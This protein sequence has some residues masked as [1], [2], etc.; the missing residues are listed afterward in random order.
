MTATRFS[1]RL[2]SVVAALVLAACGGEGAPSPDAEAAMA[3]DSTIKPV[4][5][6]PLTEADLMGFALSDLSVELPWTQNRVSRDPAP[7]QGPG[8]LESAETSSGE[9]FARVVF[10]FS[11][12]AYF[13]GYEVGFVDAGADVPCG[14][15]GKALSLSG[16][17]ALVIRLK[18]ANAH[19]TEGVRVPVRTR[20]L[21]PEQFTEGGLVCDLNDNVVWA[22]GLNSG[23]QVRV[24]EFRNPKRLAVDIR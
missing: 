1:S 2:V 6:E 22:A 18:P 19:D 12:I 3:V 11:D 4:A 9:G 13:P 15:Q 7:A 21:S 5:R 23:D 24:L 16:D 20:S 14:E 17:R 10:T 8:W